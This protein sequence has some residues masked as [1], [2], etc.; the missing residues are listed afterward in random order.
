MGDD[1][2]NRRVRKLARGSDLLMADTTPRVTSRTKVDRQGDLVYIPR[3][4]RK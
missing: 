4:D 2:P 1:T 3:K